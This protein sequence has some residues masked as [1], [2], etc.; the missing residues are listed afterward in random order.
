M[1]FKPWIT[2]DFVLAI[3]FCLFVRAFHLYSISFQCKLLSW[4]NIC[5]F[6]FGLT[7]SHILEYLLHLY[8]LVILYSTGKLSTPSTILCM[9]N[10]S[11]QIS[12]INSVILEGILYQESTSSY[13]G[14]RVSIVFTLRLSDFDIELGCDKTGRRKICVL[15]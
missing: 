8:S 12:F 2:G 11:S 1:I 9:W 15:G 4:W 13:W 5:V 10:W 3:L 14:F 6:L 7:C